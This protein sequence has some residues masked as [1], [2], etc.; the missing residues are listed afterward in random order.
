MTI[1]IGGGGTGA[2]GAG[3]VTGGNP[4]GTGTALNYIGN[5]CYAYSG[6][7]SVNGTL[8]T[9]L[10]FTTAE[11]YVVATYQIHGLFSQIGANQLQLEVTMNGESITHSFWDSAH[12]NLNPFENAI[13]I[14]PYTKITFQLAQASGSVKNMQLTLL[15]RVY[16]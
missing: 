9:M 8:L 7:V 12:D 1:V 2:G 5:H 14:P 4:S 11:Q 16:G 10:E 15:G 3:N 13:L 6:D